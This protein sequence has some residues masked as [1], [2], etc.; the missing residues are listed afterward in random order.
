M[1]RRP[2]LSWAIGFCVFWYKFIVG[3]D[4]TIA[5]AVIVGLSLTAALLAHGIS[6]WWLIPAMVIVVIA[7]DL[8]RASRARR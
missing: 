8:R 3:D 4:W 5:V 7:N 6:A 2:P 1:T